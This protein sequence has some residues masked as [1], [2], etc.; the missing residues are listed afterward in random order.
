MPITVLYI[1]TDADGLAGSSLSLGNMIHAVQGEVTPIVLVSQSSPVGD[2]F[3]SMGVKVIETPFFYLWT[4]PKPLITA[5]HHPTRTAFYQHYSLNKECRKKVLYALGGQTVDIVHTNTAVTDIGVGLANDLQAHHI[6]HIRESLAQM[7]INPHG[8]IKRLRKKI[9]HANAQIFIS[10][11]LFKE[12]HWED[13]SNAHVIHDAVVDMLPSNQNYDRKR[14]VL[15]LSADISEYKGARN[16]VEIFC[17]AGLENYELL[18][19]GR[20][21]QDYRRILHS[22]ADRF[23]M[24]EKVKIVDYQSDITSLLSSSAALIQASRFEGLGRVPIEAMAHGCPVVAFA[25]GGIL[26]FIR[27]NETG[28]LYETES[29][30]VSQL[31]KAVAHDATIIKNARHEVEMEYTETVFRDRILALYNMQK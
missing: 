18:L 21:G 23:G 28:Y 31:R 12:W 15:F 24:A 10:R 22:T 9:K 17:K 8:G 1:C 14:Q 16:A 5:L 25:S 30:A 6:W 3:R 7:G 13:K 4:R 20:C 29:D 19:A 27:N 26:D 2:Y 11:A